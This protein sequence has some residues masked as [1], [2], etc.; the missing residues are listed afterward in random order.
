MASFIAT[1]H[2]FRR[3]TRLS[4]TIKRQNVEHMPGRYLSANVR[5]NELV[6]FDLSNQVLEDFPSNFDRGDRGRAIGS[7]PS[8]WVALPP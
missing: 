1:N 3:S 6:Q 4:D 8:D 2:S 5:L 7:V